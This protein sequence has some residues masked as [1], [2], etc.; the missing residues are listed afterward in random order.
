M[1]HI[2][3]AAL[4]G[5]ALL[6]VGPAGAEQ[7]RVTDEAM[8]SALAEHSA[9]WDDAFNAN[10]ADAIVALYAEDAVEITNQGPIRGREAIKAHYEKLLERF[11]F[12]DHAGKVTSSH[13]IG[14][15]GKTVWSEGE[16]SFTASDDKGNSMPLHGYWSAISVLED[17]VWKDVMQT[18][19]VDPGPT[20]PVA[21][22]Q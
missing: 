7:M 22:V 19:N 5:A 18:W 20:P 6:A 1:K 11:K 4:L 10:T 16:Y 8:L 2:L 21:A 9:K 13:M 12:S 15:D 3:T 14:D 17:A